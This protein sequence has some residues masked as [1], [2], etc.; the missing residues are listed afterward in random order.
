MSARKASKGREVSSLSSPSNAASLSR[1]CMQPIRNPE[2]PKFPVGSSMDQAKKWAIEAANMLGLPKA[3]RR[4][5]IEL[6]IHARRMGVAWPSD[7]TLIEETGYCKRTVIRARAKLE[8]MGLYQ[9]VKQGGRGNSNRYYFVSSPASQSSL[10]LKDERSRSAGVQCPKCGCSEY[11]EHGSLLICD[12]CHESY[13]A[14]PSHK[15]KRGKLRVP[16]Q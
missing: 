5:L 8:G 16:D 15:P 10:D 3:P 12:E 6:A 4:V 11:E 2:I 7:K 9:C 14:P 1:A 13:D